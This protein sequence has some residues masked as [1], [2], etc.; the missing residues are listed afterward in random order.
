[1][2]QMQRIH[3][4]F[5]VQRIETTTRMGNDGL[6]RGLEFDASF[7]FHLDCSAIGFSHND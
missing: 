3:G 4:M 2:F 7:F 5:A 6:D 1:M